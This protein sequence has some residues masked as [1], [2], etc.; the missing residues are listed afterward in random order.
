V[1]EVDPTGTV[2]VVPVH[3]GIETAREIEIRSGDLSE[4]DNVVAGSRA[5]LKAGSK[6]RAKVIALQADSTPKL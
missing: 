2:R 6:V 5:G 4:G 3:L 1:F